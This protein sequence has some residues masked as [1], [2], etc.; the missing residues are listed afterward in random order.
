MTTSIPKGSLKQGKNAAFQCGENPHC[1][2]AVSQRTNPR[3]PLQVSVFC[4]ENLSGEQSPKVTEASKGSF[5]WVSLSSFQEA[6]HVM[7]KVHSDVLPWGQGNTK[8]HQWTEIHEGTTNL[9]VSTQ[10]YLRIIRKLSQSETIQNITSL[11]FDTSWTLCQQRLSLDLQTHTKEFT[12]FNYVEICIP[13]IP[14][15]L[16]LKANNQLSVR[17]NTTITAACKHPG[18][19]N[20]SSAITYNLRNNNSV[21]YQDTEIHPRLWL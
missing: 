20:A 5:L 2:N 11:P 3:H 19:R 15:C 7:L 10:L 21:G 6:C 12:G 16:Q 13:K 17:S 4:Q 14:T 9:P 18:N 1:S 8:M